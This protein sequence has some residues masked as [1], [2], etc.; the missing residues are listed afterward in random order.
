MHQTILKSTQLNLLRHVTHFC[1]A[2]LILLILVFVFPINPSNTHADEPQP[3]STTPSISLALDQELILNIT[4]N[5]TGA[6][7]TATSNLTV[8]TNND[9]GYKIYLETLAPTTNLTNVD[10]TRSNYHIP[11]L[12]SP[13]TLRNFSANT[14]GFALSP[15]PLSDDTAFSGF[16]D[17]STPLTSTDHSSAQDNYYFTLATNLDTSIPAGTYANTLRISAIANPA[18]ISGLMT[19]TYM[20]DM[21]S[22]ICKATAEHD[23]KQ[24]IDSRDGKEYWVAKLA[25]GNCWMTQNLAYDIPN[26]GLTT[27][28]TS[29]TDINSPNSAWTTSSLGVDTDGLPKVAPVATTHSKSLPDPFSTN[30][31]GTTSFNF[32]KYVY[33]TPSSRQN[34]P[35]DPKSYAECPNGFIDVSSSIWQPTHTTQS[36]TYQG[37]TYDYVAIDETAKTYDAHYLIGNFYFWNAATAG[38]GGK[39]TDKTA[40]DSICPKNWRLP[41]TSNDGGDFPNLFNAYALQP[42]TNDSF[43]SP[44]YL[45][46]A[47]FVHYSGKLQQ[48]GTSF[49]L[50]S[51]SPTTDNNVCYEGYSGGTAGAV[52]RSNALPVRCLAR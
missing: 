43:R 51:S 27:T 19:L 47:G 15:H 30:N 24:L 25:D 33:A 10:P 48:P 42:W 32:G 35:T 20:Q 39:I 17:T 37:S 26:T 9:T 18:T 23:T 38:S 7:N 14:W 44:L 21:T 1:L 2:L 16:P 13:T 8:A 28:I 5:S 4:P 36:G 6:T 3:Q 31:T 41:T 12:T 45:T 40:R 22:D 34:C 11:A 49:N 52:Y 50:Y 29:Q 46:Q